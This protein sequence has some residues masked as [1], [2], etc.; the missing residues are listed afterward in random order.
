MLSIAAKYYIDMLM[1]YSILI[2][3]L[4]RC[5]NTHTYIH[6]PIPSRHIPSYFTL[7]C[8]IP[9]FCAAQLYYTFMSGQSGSSTSIHL[10]INRKE[11]V[12]YGWV[13]EYRGVHFSVLRYMDIK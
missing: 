3:L 13:I 7:S 6:P 4:L 5:T 9:F 11:I 2:L 8:P 1:F 12:L 10:D